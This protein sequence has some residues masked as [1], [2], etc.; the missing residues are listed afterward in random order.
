[1]LAKTFGSAVYGVDA[2]TIT[3]EANVLKGRKYFIFPQI[4]AG[5]Q[6]LPVI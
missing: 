4:K 3:V 1:M 5:N 2:I 6:G